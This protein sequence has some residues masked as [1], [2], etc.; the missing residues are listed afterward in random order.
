[1]EQLIIGVKRGASPP[2]DWVAAL[3]RLHGVRVLSRPSARQV[4]VEVQAGAED[5][6]RHALG[7]AFHIEHR[8][9]HT[10]F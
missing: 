2:A 5:S 8:Q 3:E 4:R 7:N 10:R 9:L 1:M 6:V